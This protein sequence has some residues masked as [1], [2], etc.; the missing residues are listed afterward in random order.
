MLKIHLIWTFPFHVHD[1]TWNVIFVIFPSWIVELNLQILHRNH[2]TS[3]EM[4]SFLAVGLQHLSSFAAV[5]PELRLVSIHQPL[6]V[7]H[8]LVIVFKIFKVEKGLGSGEDS[9]KSVGSI[10]LILCL[11]EW[12]DGVGG[13]TNVATKLRKK[14]K[15]GYFFL[16]IIHLYKATHIKRCQFLQQVRASPPLAAYLHIYVYV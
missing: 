3:R 13:Q 15:I 7:G 1:L 5:C 4:S 12:Q 16:N 6:W 2:S 14:E 11:S 8:R 10:Q 9:L